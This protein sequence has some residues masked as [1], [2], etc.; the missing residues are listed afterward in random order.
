LF[1]RGMHADPAAVV[2]AIGEGGRCLQSFL[3]HPR[4]QDLFP[5]GPRSTG[6][7]HMSVNFSS[8][9]SSRLRSS[10]RRSPYSGSSLRTRRPRSVVVALRRTALTIWLASCRTWK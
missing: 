1:D 9:R 8:V 7:F 3:G 10:R 4:G 2:A 6:R 5:A